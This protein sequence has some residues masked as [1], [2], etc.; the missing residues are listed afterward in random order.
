[1]MIT[2]TIIIISEVLVGYEKVII[3]YTFSLHHKVVTQ[4]Q[5]QHRSVHATT[6]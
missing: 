5:W 4:K 3:I 2:M 6:V 1:M